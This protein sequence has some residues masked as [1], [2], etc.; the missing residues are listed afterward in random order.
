MA[1]ALLAAYNFTNTNIITCISP[2]I[3]F[4]RCGKKV[5][6]RK[7]GVVRGV[8][9][10]YSKHT[11]FSPPKQSLHH[12]PVREKC[13]YF[14]KTETYF[15]HCFYPKVRDNSQAGNAFLSVL[16]CNICLMVLMELK[17]VEIVFISFESKYRIQARKTY[18]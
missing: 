2:F 11:H 8:R 17:A 5:G 15:F 7:R 18:L 13:V 14:S 12:V 3:F 10:G 16:H 9:S 6:S 1:T 4:G